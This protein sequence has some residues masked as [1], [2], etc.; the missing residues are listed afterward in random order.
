MRRRPLSR[1][2]RPTPASRKSTSGNV[3]P[4]RSTR[5]NRRG[6]DEPSDESGAEDK[7]A[8][9][10]DDEATQSEAESTTRR[11]G[12]AQPPPQGNPRN[13][14]RRRAT[15]RTPIHVP[16]CGVAA[17]RRASKSDDVEPDEE[18]ADAKEEQASG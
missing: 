11:R 6:G 8:S 13:A 9:D 14:A 4:T 15:R 10:N 16:R 3:T 12:K 2:S 7:E 17:V 18:M 5:R 1:P